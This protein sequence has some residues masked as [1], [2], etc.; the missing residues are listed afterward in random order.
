MSGRRVLVAGWVNSPHVVA[1]ADA[2]AEL[3]DEVHVAGQL[4]EPWPLLPD[5]SL[6][7]SLH[8]LEPGQIRGIRDRR[9]GHGLAQ[10]ASD[11]RPDLVHAHWAPGYGWMSA[12]AGLRPLI[13][14]AWGS[15]LLLG[16]RRLRLRSRRA[17]RA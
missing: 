11:L 10:V 2:V 3:G 5:S 13:T 7:A 15:D 14:S 17:L 6:L 1:W 9:I 4:V 12:R 16:S 8:I